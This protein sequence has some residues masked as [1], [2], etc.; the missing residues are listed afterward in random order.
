MPNFNSDTLYGILEQIKPDIILQEM[1]SSFFTR[2]FRYK[3]PSKEN[4]QVA[5]EKYLKKH[6]ETLI[7]PFEFE[8]R[9]EYRK[10]R[11]M[12]PTDNLTTKLL[13]SL[14]K[15][16]LLTPPQKAIVKTYYDLTNQL[17][18]IASKFPEN[19]NNSKTDLIAE[20]RQYFQHKK[21]TEI[22]SKRKEFANTYLT[23]PNGE[24]ISYR[25]GYQLWADFWDLRNQTMAK[26]IIKIAALNPGKRIAVT[27]G[28][29][30]RY[31]ILSELRKLTAGKN[32][33]IK[34]FYE[35]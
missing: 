31:Y 10:A 26:N 16:N 35:Y 1:D 14:Y 34:E 6:P 3:Y 28:F 20:K 21:L 12:V 4:E 15:A 11:G 19:F 33:Q 24:K 13:D 2:D 18:L 25:D 7:R 29:L 5:T 17:K 30:H 9:N 22:T 23:K 32:I 8:G 27:T